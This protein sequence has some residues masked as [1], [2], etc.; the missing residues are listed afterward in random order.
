MST[1]VASTTDLQLCDTTVLSGPTLEQLM[2]DPDYHDHMKVFAVDQKHHLSSE[3][4]TLRFPIDVS[5]GR[6]FDRVDLTLR[7]KYIESVVSLAEGPKCMWE[8]KQMRET[9]ISALR[10]VGIPAEEHDRRLEWRQG[11]NM[12]LWSWAVQCVMSEVDATASMEDSAT[13]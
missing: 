11:W 3:A 4:P 6:A 12:L 13:V 2:T 8:E 10:G 5:L 1:T 9:A 7:G